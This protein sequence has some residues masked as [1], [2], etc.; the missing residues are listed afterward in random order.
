LAS[1]SIVALLEP[2]RDDDVLER[3]FEE[4][5]REE[6]LRADFAIFYLPPSGQRHFNAVPVPE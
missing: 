4:L 3:E 5:E 1:L 6:L 2:E